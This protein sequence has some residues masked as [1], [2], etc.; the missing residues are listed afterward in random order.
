MRP[1]EIGLVLPT[2]QFGPTRETARWPQIREIAMTAE[3][4][5]ADTVW[6]ADELLWRADDGPPRG[7]W[8]GL[9]LAGAVAAVSGSTTESRPRWARSVPPDSRRST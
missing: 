7:A 4:M 3:S 5:G 9:P 2:M 1:F 8:D 6:V